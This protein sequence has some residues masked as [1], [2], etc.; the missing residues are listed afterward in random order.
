MTKVMTSF[1][2][3]IWNIQKKMYI[4]FSASYFCLYLYCNNV[5]TFDINVIVIKILK[6]DFMLQKILTWLQIS[7]EKQWL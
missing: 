2:I 1:S 5:W 6:C 7:S 4:Y 3:I